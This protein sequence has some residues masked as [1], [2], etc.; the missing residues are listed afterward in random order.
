MADNEPTS[1]PEGG[2]P[3]KPQAAN[4]YHKQGRLP[5]SRMDGQPKASAAPISVEIG[6]PRRRS[7]NHN[8]LMHLQRAHLKKLG[9]VAGLMAALL[10]AMVKLVHILSARD[11]NPAGASPPAAPRPLKTNQLGQVTGVRP[12]S[13]ADTNVTAVPT[14]SKIETEKLMRAAYLARVARTFEDNNDLDKAAQKYREALDVWPYTP[15]VWAQ[16]GRV[17]LRQHD[18]WH[19][20]VALEKAI[21]G[22]PGAVEVL[23]NLGVAY[24][25]RQNLESARKVFQAALDIDPNY[26]L[27]Y[28]NLALC[29]IAQNDRPQARE[30]LEQFLRMKPDDARGL[31]ELACLKAID[32]ERDE[33]LTDLEPALAQAPD[34]PLHYFDA[35]VVSALLGDFEKSIRYL[36]K[37]E[38]L[39]GPSNVY[40]IYQEPPFKEL[41]LTEAGKL[42]E[43]D[44]AARAREMISRQEQPPVPTASDPMISTPPPATPKP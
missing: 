39:S 3:G 24:L 10:F 41:R 44:L 29:L 36:E 19:A 25:W 42:F 6:R 33:A 31:R 21:E 1:R 2:E 12:M 37:A 4:L 7:S 9:I 14:A 23:N 16:L 18:Y 22:N 35:A 34:W 5:R 38:P 32:N 8:P 43:K 20:Q 28:F 30:R 17:Y 13:P 15:D 11:A 26:A 40:K 27:T